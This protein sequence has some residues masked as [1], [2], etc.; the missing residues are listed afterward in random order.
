M[1]IQSIPKTIVVM[2][3]SGCGK[4]F[5]GD[6]LAQALGGTFADADDFHPPANIE[7]MANGIPLTDADRWPWLDILREQIVSHRI[8]TAFYVLA[9]SAL[10]HSYRDRLR[11]DDSQEILNFVYLKG[12]K[13][14]I[15][16]RMEQRDHFMPSAL[17]DSQFNTL[18]EPQDAIDVE[19]ALS[20]DDIVRMILKH[21]NDSLR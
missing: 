20:P 17:L 21:F 5:I 12:S 18:E 16:Q 3:V 7:K 1:Q 6:R 15:L 13:E 2:G 11:G 10:K 4:S 14:L 9:C 19:M 8:R